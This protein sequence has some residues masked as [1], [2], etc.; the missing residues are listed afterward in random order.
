MPDEPGNPDVVV[1]QSEIVNERNILS[2]LLL[3]KGK[4]LG[5]SRF[6]LDLKNPG[7]MYQWQIG[8]YRG[9]RGKGYSK[10]LL[11]YS[12]LYIFEKYK[13]LKCIHVDTHPTNRIMINLL[14]RIGYQYTHT[15]M[16]YENED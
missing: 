14:K 3:S 4:I 7:I 16:I 8:I 13:K 11:S 10:Y 5:L 12:Y 2:F 15:D 6:Y 9:Y 1:N